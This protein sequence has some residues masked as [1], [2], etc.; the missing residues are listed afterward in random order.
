MTMTADSPRRAKPKHRAAPAGPDI[1]APLDV[2]DLEPAA[3]V[4]LP[5]S[6]TCSDMLYLGAV[7]TL[8]GPPDCGKTTLAC[9][10]MLQAI[11]GERTVLFLDEEGG[12]ELITEK[13]QALGAKTGERIAY[14]PFPG[15]GWGT[16]DVAALAA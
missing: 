9:R 12:R 13:F 5:P 11:R 10:W 4:V 8:T 7:H 6:L 15:R 3:D 14:V 2:I 16:A 1:P